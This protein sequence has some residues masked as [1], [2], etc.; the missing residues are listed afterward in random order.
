MTIVKTIGLIKRY[1]S[2][3]TAN[4]LNLEVMEGEIL[5]ILGPNGAEEML[6]E[7]DLWKLKRNEQ[8]NYQ[9]E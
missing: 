6:K 9:A 3:V 7:L 4:N 1:G 5:G 2:N 8:T